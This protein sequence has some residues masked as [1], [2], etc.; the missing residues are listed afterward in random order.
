MRNNISLK[1]SITAKLFTIGFLILL[2]L[3]PASMVRSLIKERERT[4]ESA[5]R[6]VSYKWGKAQTLA[7]PILTVPYKSYLSVKKYNEEKVIEQIHY[8]HFLPE[9]LN[10]KGNISPEIL[11]RG[12][13][14]VV[15]Y[16][17][18]L[19]F[20]GE[21]PPI[22]FENFNIKE[23]DIL[24][25]DAFISLGVS[26]MRGIEKNIQAKWNEGQ[27][28]FGPGIEAKDVVESGVSVQIPVSSMETMKRNHLFS[29]DISLNGSKQLQF[30][31]IGKETNVQLIS[32][33]NNPSFDGA[34]L[35]DNREV[36]DE[37]FNASWRIL[38]LN[39]NYPQHWLGKG[40]NINILSSAIN[41]I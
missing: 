9:I 14:E 17:T 7:G 24:W 26:D 40:Q 29:F 27:F 5:I 22:N 19:K 39:R 32:N 13:Y 1:N 30:I 36:T 20:D 10:I 25:K 15:V 37:G 35:P 18:D 12:I 41:Y 16:K 3:I 38:H 21:F 4:K 2:L 11:Y 31:P 28:E 34:F 33:W 8:A 23:K 6:E